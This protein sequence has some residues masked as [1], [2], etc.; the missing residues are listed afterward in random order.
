MSDVLA[1][2]WHFI[3]GLSTAQFVTL[4]CIVGAALLASSGTRFGFPISVVVIAGAVFAYLA[5][6]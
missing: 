6:R 5:G 3:D 4:E 1:D 2:L